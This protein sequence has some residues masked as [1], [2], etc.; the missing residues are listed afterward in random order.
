VNPLLDPSARGLFFV[1]LLTAAGCSGA[2]PPLSAAPIPSAE[3]S[4][5]A[6]AAPDTAPLPP[7]VEEGMGRVHSLLADP[8]DA[9]IQAAFSPRFLAAVPPEKVKAIFSGIKEE[10]GVCPK[11]APL[12]VKDETAAAVRV[13]CDHGAI[14]ASIL[15][16]PSI[17]HLI[18]G[19][20]LKPAER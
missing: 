7:L 17:P 13:E 12:T 9:A 18:E 14:D 1:A 16:N 15:V 11:H 19:L 2:P 3:P 8:S 6:P 4:A 5:L 10:H 20:V